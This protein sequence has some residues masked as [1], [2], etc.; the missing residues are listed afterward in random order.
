MQ[1]VILRVFLVTEMYFCDLH[2][3]GHFKVPQKYYNLSRI[4]GSI[5][6]MY[7]YVI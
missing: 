3:V 5:D 7:M 4:V 6:C 2:Y 1:K